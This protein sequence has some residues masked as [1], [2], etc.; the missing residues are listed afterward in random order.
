MQV[1]PKPIIDYL[2]NICKD[3]G[4]TDFTWSNL[5]EEREKLWTARHNVYWATVASKP[6]SRVS[7]IRD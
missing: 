5:P 4:G 1:K 3:N 7:F 6:G 2:G